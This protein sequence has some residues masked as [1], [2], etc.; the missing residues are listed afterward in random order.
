MVCNLLLSL[1]SQ[2]TLA[3][4]QPHG[5]D[6]HQAA[7][8]FLPGKVEEAPQTTAVVPGPGLALQ[9]LCLSRPLQARLT[10]QACL[11]QH[12]V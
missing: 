10:L 5:G 7:R 9:G 6:T 11:E 1:L 3:P 8:C 12:E 4:L 2:S